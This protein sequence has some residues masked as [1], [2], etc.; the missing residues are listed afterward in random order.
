MAIS[1]LAMLMALNLASHDKLRQGEYLIGAV[2]LL[3]L[4]AFITLCYSPLSIEFAIGQDGVNLTVQTPAEG[5]PP[6]P[7]EPQQWA[8]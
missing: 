8:G 4:I 3:M 1:P 6:R 2:A 5:T 7:T